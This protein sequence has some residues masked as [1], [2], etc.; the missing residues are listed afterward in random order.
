MPAARAKKGGTPP[1]ALE[2]R[3]GCIAPDPP[4]DQGRIQDEWL[5]ILAQ[6]RCTAAR[7]VWRVLAQQ[8]VARAGGPS[9]L[10]TA[11]QPRHTGR[12][13]VSASLVGVGLDG[14]DLVRLGVSAAGRPLLRLHLSDAM[15]ALP[16]RT[17]GAALGPHVM[18]GM[19]RIP[20]HGGENWSMS[21]TWGLL[22]LD[23]PASATSPRGIAGPGCRAAI[24]WM[25]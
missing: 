19:P 13:S 24:G 23:E 22:A 14:A 2:C 12:L 15:C 5:H 8:H 3:P 10:Q 16:A 1:R 25:R 21:C 6:P 18:R 4:V 7:A 9:L 17:T 20:R 11:L